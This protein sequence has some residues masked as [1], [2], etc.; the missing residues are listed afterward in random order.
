[1][2]PEVLHLVDHSFGLKSD[3]VFRFNHAHLR[4][5]KMWIKWQWNTGM[6]SVLVNNHYS[7]LHPSVWCSHFLPPLS[8]S[9]PLWLRMAHK[10]QSQLTFLME[11]HWF[12]FG[13][14]WLA[15]Q[16]C[17]H[18]PPIPFNQETG[19]PADPEVIQLQ[20]AFSGVPRCAP[21]YI[22]LLCGCTPPCR[23]QEEVREETK[24]DKEKAKVLKTQVFRTALRTHGRPTGLMCL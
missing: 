12:L 19:Q 22:S 11:R 16:S 15:N 24:A 18:F 21:L 5:R 3:S 7:W 6:L 2:N 4:S 17:L 20:I 1:M 23:L 10:G 9:P 13:A 14:L 8:C